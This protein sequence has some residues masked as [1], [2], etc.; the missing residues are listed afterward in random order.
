VLLAVVVI[1]VAFGG[2]MAIP[3]VNSAMIGLFWSLVEFR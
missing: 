3:M 1:L 2:I